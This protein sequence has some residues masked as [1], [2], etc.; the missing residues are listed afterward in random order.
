MWPWIIRGGLVLG[1]AL[2]GIGA[3]HLVRRSRRSPSVTQ[4]YSALD[5]LQP[6]LEDVE[7]LA[8]AREARRARE[9]QEALTREA[10]GGK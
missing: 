7:A 1:G 5:V 9:A 6:L 4:M 8:G 3:T 10:R 2:A